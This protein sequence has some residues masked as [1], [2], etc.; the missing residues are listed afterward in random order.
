MATLVN[1]AEL[2]RP[3]AFDRRVLAPMLRVATA[4]LCVLLCPGSAGS[5]CMRGFLSPSPLCLGPPA[6]NNPPI[7][8]LPGLLAA[9]IGRDIEEIYAGNNKNV[10]ADVDLLQQITGESGRAGASLWG[11][12]GHPLCEPLG[13]EG[14]SAGVVERG[15]CSSPW[16]ASPLPSAPAPPPP[17]VARAR[18]SPPLPPLPP[19]EAC[20]ACVR[21]FVKDRTG[22]D[23]RI[24]T[25]WL[26]QLSKSLGLSVEPWVRALQG[27][28]VSGAR[29]PSCC[30]AAH[31]ICCFPA[32]SL[33][34][35]PTLPAPTLTR[36]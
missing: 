29:E 14:H 31:I 16:P 15:A 21:E 11:F 9:A 13:R 30:S 26:A 20:R 33:A 4:K 19:A 5:L 35:P 24:G 18:P 34:Q 28:Q 23:G 1:I 25:N 7:R 17:H 6:D 2:D 27:T 36:N 12:A 22:F 3:G 8:G 10:L 32:C